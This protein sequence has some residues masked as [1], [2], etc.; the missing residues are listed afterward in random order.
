MA[1]RW[2]FGGSVLGRSASVNGFAQPTIRQHTIC[3]TRDP[4]LTM[5]TTHPQE[6]V[7]RTVLANINSVFLVAMGRL[8]LDRRSMA[9]FLISATH[10]R[11]TIHTTEECRHGDN[12]YVVS[13]LLEVLGLGYWQVILLIPDGAGGGPSSLILSYILHGHIPYYNGHH[14]DPI[15][16]A[17]LSRNPN[18]LCI[19]PD[20]YAHFYSSL[21]YSTQA[22]PVNTLLDTLVRPNA[23]TVV[24]SQTCVEW[25]YE[26]EKAVSH[27]V[28]T[29]AATAGGQWTDNPAHTSVD[30]ATLS[31][32]E[33][34][35]LPGYSYGAHFAAQH[36]GRPAPA[37]ERPS[38]AQAA[39]YYAAYPSAAGIASTL[40]TSVTVTRVSRAASGSGFTL[41]MHTPT[42]TP[43]TLHA[44]HVVLA[45][46]IFSHAPSAPPPLS[47]LPGPSA[48]SSSSSSLPLLVIGSGFTA[49]DVLLSG[50][51][52]RP[53][54]HVFRWAPAARPSPLK[55]CHASA[56][57]EYA[58]VYRAMR[59]AATA[60]AGGSAAA[61]AA[62]ARRPSL[63]TSLLDE[64]CYEGFANG[65]V[66]G[67][68]RAA[69]AGA[70]EVA[71]RCADGHVE[72]RVV[73]GLAYAV[74]RRGNLAY[75]DR[76][77]RR[78]V[79]GA[80]AAD[81][82]YLDGHAVR[83]KVEADVQVAPGVFVI[84]GLTGDSL[85][86]HAYGGCVQAAGEIMGVAK[87]ANAQQAQH[88]V[89]QTEAIEDDTWSHEDSKLLE[90]KLAHQDLHLDRWK[91]V[92]TVGG[93]LQLLG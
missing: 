90:S 93:H 76:A 47:Q 1:V 60:T 15:L 53:A 69:L 67:V 50:P 91:L 80:A 72:R 61:A 73:G 82:E 39:S 30:I 42:H 35:S 64:G 81:R 3:P 46:G 29:S 86:R 45:S 52:G 54:Y 55:A 49:A 56:Y 78:E 5:P 20:L 88:Y 68:E 58:R 66:V 75:L 59:R 22:L 63:T 14:H 11:S 4:S 85:V 2:Q 37:F 34:L 40:H 65:E 28:L 48:A 17:K 36:N 83:D 71:I 70:W 41:T 13:S 7:G 79:L 38:R 27:V 21:R 24:D 57:P 25:R 6:A 26:P 8:T 44:T 19:T 18:L 84:G 31:Y 32:S 89:S 77:L 33:M 74:G 12:R 16:D 43:H 87:S 10:G 62:A 92:D 51:R 9:E 23:D